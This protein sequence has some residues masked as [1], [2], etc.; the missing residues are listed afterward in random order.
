MK[1]VESNLLKCV[2]KEQKMRGFVSTY[3]STEILYDVKCSRVNGEK[4]ESE[5]LLST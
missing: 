4:S 5:K 1:K 3:V 2:A